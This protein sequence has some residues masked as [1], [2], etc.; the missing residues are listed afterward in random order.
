M[1]TPND[2]TQAAKEKFL[3][4]NRDLLALTDNG[5]NDIFRRISASLALNTEAQEDVMGC[6]SASDGTN[7]LDQ[8]GFAGQSARESFSRE[9]YKAICR[10]F[11]KI[12]QNLV[13]TWAVK[14]T[15]EAL[16]QLEAIEV[17]AGVRQAPAPIAPPPPA[18]TA[19]EQLEAEVRR[20]WVHL[21]TAEV[22]RKMN[23][24]AYKKMFDRLMDS[25][26]L[27]SQCTT[28]YTD[29]EAQR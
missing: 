3:D 23:N 16:A 13:V 17:V 18:P 12:Q 21:R 25:G 27:A 28:H 11:I 19:A 2:L 5:P 6:V 8:K 1:S 9:I 29:G 10:S 22:R 14:L 15:P 4:V 24:A 26:Q 7:L 20:D